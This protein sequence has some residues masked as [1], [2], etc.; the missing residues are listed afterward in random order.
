MDGFININKEPGWTSHDVVA[1]LRGILRQKKIGHAGTLDPAAQGVLPVCLGKA[2]RLAE[3]AAQCGKRYR[4]EITFGIGTD[5]YDAE[6]RVVEQKAA[7]HLKKEA[8]EA[9]LAS[10]TGEIEQTP[11]MVSALKFRGEPLYKLARKGVEIERPARRVT[12]HGI[13]TVGYTEGENPRLTIDITCS[14]GTYIR[15]LAHDLGRSLSVCAHLSALCRLAV[16]PFSLPEAYTVAQVKE[17]VARQSWDFL[18]PMSIGVAALPSFTVSGPEK[19]KLLCGVP[20][21]L[22]PREDA[23]PLAVLDEIGVL[24]GVGRIKGAVLYMDKVL[25]AE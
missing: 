1:A 15:S 12:V 11:P 16:G 23:E 17:L 19:K 18:L 3:Y 20:V 21:A 24:L 9:A 25:A 6:G 2:T 10:F 13:E 7:G 14:K 5:S 22:S 4:G 8:V